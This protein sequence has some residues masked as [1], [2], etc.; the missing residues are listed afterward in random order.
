[1]IDIQAKLEKGWT[2]EQIS[3]RDKE[4]EIF[5]ISFK[6]IYLSVKAGLLSENAE[7]FYQEKEKESKME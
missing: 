1:M 3:G 4:E 2:P 5:K 7:N 6:T